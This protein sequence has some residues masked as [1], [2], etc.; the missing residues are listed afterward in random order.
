M[1]SIPEESDSDADAT[2]LESGLA[3]SGSRPD[4]SAATIRALLRA[5]Y[6]RDNSSKWTKKHALPLFLYACCALCMVALVFTLV[7]ESH[8]ADAL[9]HSPPTHPADPAF[10][11]SELVAT[12]TDTATRII[13]IIV[14]TSLAVRAALR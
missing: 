7:A 8:P 6:H 1:P 14:A 3:T 12:V 2:D 9:A 4:S 5:M 10:S 13:D 11:L